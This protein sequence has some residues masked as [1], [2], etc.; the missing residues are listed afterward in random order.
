LKRDAIIAIL[1]IALVAGICYGL[2]LMK[3]D[4]PPTPSAP[5][6]TAKV[7]AQAGGNVVMRV[8]DEPITAEEYEA[9]F[10]QLPDD[11]KQQL[12]ATP[13]GKTAFA[14]QLV[15]YKLLEQEARRLGVDKEPRV[16]AMIAADRTSI[17]AS[18]VAQKL[19]GK[20]TDQAVRDFYA[21]H[22]KEF[23]SMQLAHI[24]IAY[25]GGMAPPR[26][27]STALPQAQ[28]MAKAR[29]IIK[30]LRG[31]ASFAQLAVQHSDDI[32]SAERGGDLGTVPAA[33]LPPQIVALKEGEISDP[34][35]S[36]SGVHIFRGGKRVTQSIDQV[37]GAISQ[38]VQRQ[39][40]F[41][42]I[43]QLRKDAKV[44]FDE[45]FFPETRRKTPKKT[46]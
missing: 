44:D 2:S 17:L 14:E 39:N 21:G 37:R 41:D 11:V 45:K 20:P 13:Q 18:A 22:S 24:L 35:P 19:V 23:E 34:M 3:L 12:T 43:E 26:P 38:Q 9:A 33:Q 36:A 5:Y 1:V 29:E 4:L 10:A 16:A 15:R 42:R 46:S 7:G 28:A 25:Q 30:Q 32:A 8:N 6:S 27:G 31:G 40:T